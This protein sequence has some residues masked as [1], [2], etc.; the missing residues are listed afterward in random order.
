MMAALVLGIIFSL[1]RV[2]NS[3]TYGPDF[4]GAFQASVQVIKQ[5]NR[6]RNDINERDAAKGLQDKLSPFSDVP[7]TVSFMGK[8]HLSVTI[9]RAVYNDNQAL[10]RSA[11]ET[12]GGMFVFNYN[13]QANNFEDLYTNQDALT[14]IGG[15]TRINA[16]DLFTNRLS[17]ESLAT[18]NGRSPYVSLGLQQANDGQFA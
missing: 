12:T 8:D 16:S 14:A 6:N 4:N 10:F 1:V 3:L 11:I 5:N 2:D 9:A 15:T 17:V 18:R 7:V 13:Q